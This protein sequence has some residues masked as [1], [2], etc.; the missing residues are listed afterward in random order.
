MNTD[1]KF[2]LEVPFKETTADGREVM[3]TAKLEGDTLTKTQVTGHDMPD[4]L[5]DVIILV[6]GGDGHDS[7]GGQAVP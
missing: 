6:S 2:R 3:T 1:I 5:P 4:R 7:G